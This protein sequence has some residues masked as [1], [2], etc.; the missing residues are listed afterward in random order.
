MSGRGSGDVYY[1]FHSKQWFN[2]KIL[3]SFT[4]KFRPK[5]VLRN[6]NT[7]KQILNLAQSLL[8]LTLMTTDL[9]IFLACTY[10]LNDQSNPLLFILFGNLDLV[11]RAFG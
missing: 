5:E 2:H 8:D 6:N 7:I 1:K 9:N 11:P 3:Q 10:E 4:N